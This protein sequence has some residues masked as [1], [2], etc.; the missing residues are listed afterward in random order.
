[1]DHQLR[2]EAY[3]GRDWD[4]VLSGSIVSVAFTEGT[5][6]FNDAIVTR[7]GLWPVQ[8]WWWPGAKL[9]VTQPPAVPA[10]STRD[11]GNGS[12]DHRSLN[13]KTSPSV[14]A[15]AASLALRMAL[16]RNG[17]TTGRRWLTNP[18][19]AWG[20]GPSP[21]FLLSLDPKET[22]RI[23]CCRC[24]ADGTAHSFRTAAAGSGDPQ[25]FGPFPGQF[26]VVK[27][28]LKV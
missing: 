19:S 11:S 18:L 3:R 26:C 14:W 5:L 27:A 25:R 21:L 9:D 7:T 17:R 1:M 24:V 22:G 8:T 20:N 15:R 12:E 16:V 6:S 2:C 10:H 4:N 23:N 28:R 13:A